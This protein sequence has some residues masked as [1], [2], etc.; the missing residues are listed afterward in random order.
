[1]SDSRGRWVW[2]EV[3]SSDMTKAEAFYK[4]L[5]DWT[6]EAIDLGEAGPYTM[7]KAGELP[8]VGIGPSQGG[9]PSHWLSYLD[10]GDLD[11]AMAKVPDLGGEILAPAFEIP[12]IGR[13]GIVKDSVGA[14]VALFE[15]AGE[16][17]Q[18]DSSAAPAMYSVCWT[19]HMTRDP[20]K[21]VAFYSALVGWTAEDMAPDMKVFKREGTM[22][23]SVRT[24]PDEAQDV[25]SHWMNY[26]LVPEVDVH[27]AKAE[28][29]GATILKGDT[30][31]PNM[32]RF[33][34]IQDPAG[35]VFCLWKHTAPPQT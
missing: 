13:A 21:A 27:Q 14:A 12:N 16:E 15:G 2:H 24:L 29:L 26:L 8:V 1:M 23:S 20:D 25:P 18:R 17:E 35:A 6:G 30:E 7:F 9:A 22:V 31:I 19:E 11:E 3:M 4:D 28:E 32:G 5:F 10:V 34:L 33:A